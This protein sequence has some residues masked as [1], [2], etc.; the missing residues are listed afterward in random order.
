M[1]V[2]VH[3]A[4]SRI[5]SLHWLTGSLRLNSTSSTYYHFVCKLNCT[6]CRLHRCVCT[7]NIL[8]EI[9][10]R[11][12]S[13]EL[14]QCAREKEK[15]VLWMFAKSSLNT[16]KT[17][18]RHSRKVATAVGNGS[19][20]SLNIFER[21]KRK[22]FYFCSTLI[23]V[24]FIDSTHQLLPFHSVVAVCNFLCWD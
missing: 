22:I 9:V 12:S 14:K 18:T 16:L 19:I 4:L 7:Q 6:F 8:G 1:Q 20:V 10:H 5:S 2:S 15:Q 24:V 11:L 13:I 21:M 23:V 3:F 17:K